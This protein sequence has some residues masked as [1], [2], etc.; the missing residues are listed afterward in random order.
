MGDCPREDWAVVDKRVEFPVFSAG[1]DACGAVQD[2][3]IPKM[4]EVNFTV[5]IGIDV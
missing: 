2:G 1:V 4:V 3:T 5:G